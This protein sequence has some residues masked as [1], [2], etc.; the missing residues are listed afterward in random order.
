MRESTHHI[1][2]ETN[3]PFPFAP[4]ILATPTT[5]QNLV[6]K[7]FFSNNPLSS[8]SPHS[9]APPPR[10]SP[11]PQRPHDACRLHGTLT[12]NKV[13]GNFHL[14]GGKGI[15]YPRGHFH[16][17]RGNAPEA[18]FSHRIHRFAFGDATLALMNPLE[19]DERTLPEP[20]TQ[21]QYFIEVVPTSVETLLRTVHTYQYAVREHVRLL[22]RDGAFGDGGGGMPGLHFKY[23]LAALRVSVRPDREHW[24]Y[25]L[26]RLG[27]IAAGI[28][29]LS[30][31]LNGVLQWAGVRLEAE[32]VVKVVAAP[33]TGDEAVRLNVVGTTGATAAAT[34]AAAGGRS[35]NLLLNA[36]LPASDGDLTVPAVVVAGAVPMAAETL[37]AI[38]SRVI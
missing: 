36:A 6:F 7:G 33:T 2:A 11:K 26:V 31:A 19:G 37:G 17:E 4:S 10:S 35:N 25:L 12:V 23:D 38:D 13:A 27:S 22:G 24:L 8:L 14:I 15:D 34:A 1:T 28:V 21:A 3:H 30:G 20:N 16:V 18:N 32:A 29:W 5:P 9:N